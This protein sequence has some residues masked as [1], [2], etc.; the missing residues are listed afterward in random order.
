MYSEQC[1]P[2]TWEQ[3]THPALARRH[4]LQRYVRS[5]CLT[6]KS[7]VHC[8]SFVHCVYY[9]MSGTKVPTTDTT[10][11]VS[12][13]P[14]ISSGILLHISWGS[15]TGFRTGNCLAVQWLGLSTFTVMAQVQSLVRELKIPQSMRHDPKRRIDTL[16]LCHCT[17]FFFSLVTT[18]VRRP[19][20]SD[21]AL[22]LS[23][24]YCLQ[25]T[26]FSFLSL[27]SFVCTFY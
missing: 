15:G 12:I 24:G 2:C 1:P 25:S 17:T 3:R 21:G 6:V 13:S 23:S 5:S 4:R 20:L 14:V 27:V 7:S 9:W 18:F 16:T 22:Q 8:C 11:E 10:A 26:S 19:L